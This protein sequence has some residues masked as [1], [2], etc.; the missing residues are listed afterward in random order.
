MV[1]MFSNLVHLGWFSADETVEMN[2]LSLFNSVLESRITG[3]DVVAATVGDKG[4][5]SVVNCLVPSSISVLSKLHLIT[6]IS[7]VNAV[8]SSVD[9]CEN[10]SL[11]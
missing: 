6:S 3:A 2:S 7:G 10:I 11:D 1:D 8:D 9:M 4:L 5:K